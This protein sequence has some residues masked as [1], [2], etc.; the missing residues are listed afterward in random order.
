MQ[1][2][3]QEYDTYISLVSWVLHTTGKRKT[4]L[5]FFIPLCIMCMSGSIQA[6]MERTALKV[7]GHAWHA[8]V[9]VKG[10]NIQ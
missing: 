8:A 1:S 4:S 10:A 7:E 6:I 9:N 2:L 3:G 5:N